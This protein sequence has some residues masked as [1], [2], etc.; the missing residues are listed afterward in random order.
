MISI[1]AAA[2]IAPRLETA[3]FLAPS[4]KMEEYSRLAEPISGTA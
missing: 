4:P 1:H 2:V 3:A